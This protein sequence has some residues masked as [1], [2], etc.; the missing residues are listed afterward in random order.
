MFVVVQRVEVD[1]D[2]KIIHTNDRVHNVY[3]RFSGVFMKEETI[4]DPILQKEVT[5]SG[6]GMS[7]MIGKFVDD[8]IAED[9]GGTFDEEGN[10]LAGGQ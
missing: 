2:G 1:D 8:W 6:A 10:L 9:M 7:L 3:R 5:V 4:Y